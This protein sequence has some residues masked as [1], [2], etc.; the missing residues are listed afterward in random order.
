M[1]YTFRRQWAAAGLPERFTQP[2]HENGETHIIYIIYTHST[3]T[4]PSSIWHVYIYI[5]LKK[6]SVDK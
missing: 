6:I 3:R 5:Y 1:Y 4:H 2:V